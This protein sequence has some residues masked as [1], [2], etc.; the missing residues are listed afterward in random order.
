MS[1]E[2]TARD[3]AN[4]AEKMVI[5]LPQTVMSLLL[6]LSLNGDD[7]VD[8]DPAVAEHLNSVEA[9]VSYLGSQFQME[10]ETA[11]APLSDDLSAAA[12]TLNAT[13]LQI[14]GQLANEVSGAAADSTR[15][16]A[17]H[18]ENTLAPQ[19][20]T[21]LGALFTQ[22][23]TCERASAKLAQDVDSGALAQ[24]DSLS[25]QIGFIAVNAAVEAARVGDA[26][27]G[28]SV[29]AAEIKALSDKSRIAVEQMRQA[30][31]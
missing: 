15:T 20:A 22:V 9:A 18:V 16:I 3:V 25:R 6:H 17:T 28:F 29:I 19:I 11:A 27:R 12:Q 23:V 8:A 30:V 7:V 26:G 24:I 5:G 10:F 21:F 1:D 14:H 4:L 31:A 2:M 13:L